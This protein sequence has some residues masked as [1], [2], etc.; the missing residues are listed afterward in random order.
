MNP[1]ISS[2]CHTHS[3]PHTH[4]LLRYCRNYGKCSLKL[5]EKAVNQSLIDGNQ[6]DNPRQ[7]CTEMCTVLVSEPAT[8][9]KYNLRNMSASICLFV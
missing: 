8:H 9:E 7:H 4:S 6:V 5:L 1:I 2:L 3:P